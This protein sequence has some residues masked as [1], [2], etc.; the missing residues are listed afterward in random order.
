MASFLFQKSPKIVSWRPLGPS[1]A[2]LGASWR[3]P[4]LSWGRLGGV[5]GRLGGLLEQLRPSW[6]RPGT[7]WETSKPS[8]RSFG[9][10]KTP[11][12]GLHP[13]AGA[14]CAEPL[15]AIRQL[16][17]PGQLAV[18]WP[19]GLTRRIANSSKKYQALETTKPI[20]ADQKP[21]KKLKAQLSCGNRIREV[22]R[23]KLV[24]LT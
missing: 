15:L 9:T 14:E 11:R 16:G 19:C 8:R 20:N 24:F 17:R 6:Q 13:C 2:H 22:A 12:E 21:A 18:N 23:R 5:L 4:G 7:F 10:K 1:W 3:P